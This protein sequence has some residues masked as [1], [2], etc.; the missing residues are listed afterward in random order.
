MSHLF[1]LVTN[2]L[3]PSIEPLNNITFNLDILTSHRT[4]SKLASDERLG[5][6]EEMEDAEAVEDIRKLSLTKYPHRFSMIDYIRLS[7]MAR[8]THLDQLVVL[9]QERQ[10]TV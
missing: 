2:L 4:T 6:G 5:P 1:S 7:E 10:D 9:A 3:R 8:E